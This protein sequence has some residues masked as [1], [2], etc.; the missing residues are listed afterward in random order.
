MG[1]PP[2]LVPFLLLTLFLL[3]A[4]LALSYQGEDPRQQYEQCKQQCQ[5]QQYGEQQRECERQCEKE[6]KEQREQEEI[7]GGIDPR[8]QYEQCQR[9][10]QEQQHG[11]R[12]QRECERKCEEEYREQRERG[13]AKKLN[14]E[15]TRQQYEQCQRQCQQQ[16][17]G[18]RQERE[19]ERQCEEDYRQQTERGQGGEL[20]RE[21]RRQQYEQCQKQ[22]QQ[23]HRGERQQRECERQCKEEYREQRERGQGGEWNREDPRQQFEQCKRQCQQQEHRQQRRCEQQCEEEYRESRGREANPTGQEEI[24]PY[25]FG[26]ERFTSRISTQH[27]NV[28]VLERFSRM[29]DDLLRGIEN[30]RVAILEANPKAFILPNHWDAE[31]VLYVAQG[32]ATIN[33]IRQEGK[34][35]HNPRRESH[36]LKQGDIFRVPAGTT[37]YLV[38]RDN[39]E[40]LYIVKVLQPV[41]TPGQYEPFFGVGGENPESFYRSFSDELLQAAFNA[42]KEKLQRVF[43]Q[44]REGA[45]IRATDEQIKEMSRGASSSKG[46]RWPFGE[47]SSGPYNLLNKRPSYSNDHGKLYEVDANDYQPLRDV[48]ISVS[49]ANITRG[50]MT[51]P[52]YDSK[53]TKISIV[54]EG[55]GNYEMVCPHLSSSGRRREEEEGQQEGPVSYQKVTGRLSPG[56]VFVDPAGHP[57][58]AVASGDQNLQIVCFEI[59]AKNN[60]RYYLAG[61]NNILNEL[62]REAKE[63]SFKAPAKEVEEILNAQK[64]AAFLPG[65]QQRQEKE[66]GE[67]GRADL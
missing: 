51:A 27:G 36:N 47:P 13:R 10:C 26:Q 46:G 12:Q 11:E 33:L 37:V 56:V 29:S 3:S 60:Q 53:S 30:Y 42:P 32:R 6:Y 7:E 50:S 18:K 39:N 16:H 63:L 1:R 48:D 62:E 43:G 17:R 58:M 67:G 38:N 31:A 28:R 9:Q 61:Q 35:S 44:Q 22:C 2:T 14:G 45:I 25:F 15:D 40:K 59:N 65:P 21:D 5:Q 52:Y 20:N 24:N 8:Q 54:L 41:F 49:F 66:R 34:E 64:E 55:N 19:C 23:Q 57:T 4:T